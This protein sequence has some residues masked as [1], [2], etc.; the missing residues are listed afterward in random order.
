M[1]LFDNISSI[2]N[3]GGNTALAQSGINAAREASTETQNYLSNIGNQFQQQLQFKPYTVTTGTGTSAA[4]GAGTTSTLSPELQALVAQLTGAAGGMFGQTGQPI[5][6]RAAALTG[7][8]E[9]AASPSRERERLALEE[10]LLGQGRLGVQTSMFGGT[11]EQLA[12]AK[13]VEEQRMGNALMGRQQAM[14]EQ[15]Q[16]YNIGAGLFGQSFL[17]QQMMMQQLQGATPFAQLTASGQ[18]QGA[19]TNANLQLAGAE[20]RM[21]GEQQANTLRQVQ[22]QELLN[23]FTNPQQAGG[24]SPLS[25]LLSRIFGG[26]TPE[27]Y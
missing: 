20:S 17:P 1:A 3:I 25:G 27:N 13:A 6:Q 23:A 12:M 15:L 22:L 18:Q 19:V 9:A 4:T 2:L 7:Q 10:R 16:D 8:L 26:G 24:S 14:G 21:Q 11:P 5:D